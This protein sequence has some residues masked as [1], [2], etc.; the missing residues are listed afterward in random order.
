MKGFRFVT[1]AVVVIVLAVVGT[2][3]GC[4]NSQ[5]MTPSQPTAAFAHHRAC[6]AQVENS[7]TRRRARSSTA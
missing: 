7:P 5:P 4:N 6:L 3:V 1:C 2:T